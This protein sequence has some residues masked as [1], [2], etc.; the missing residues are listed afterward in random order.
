MLTVTLPPDVAEETIAK[1]LEKQVI[2]FTAIHFILQTY[3]CI[4]KYGSVL[5][6]L[7]EGYLLFLAP[8][9]RPATNNRP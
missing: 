6:Y 3:Q 5:L 1:I 8:F 9:M 4:K 7:E 2:F